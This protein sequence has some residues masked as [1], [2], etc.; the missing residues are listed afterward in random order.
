MATESTKK[1][2]KNLNGTLTGEAAVT[3]SAGS[4]DADRIPALN[5]QG[6][7]DA[8]IVNSTTSS[9]GVSDKNKLVALD[10]TG[11]ISESMFPAGF[12]SNAYSAVCSETVVAGDI[13][14]VWNDEDQIKCRKA[15]ASGGVG[16]MAVGYV[17]EGAE[18]GASVLVY[19]EGTITGLSGLTVGRVF[20]SG[21]MAGKL[22]N[23]AP[24]TDGYV[25]QDLG[26]AISDT[27]VVF[28]LGTIFVV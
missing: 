19:N 8:T 23:T 12:G 14:N 5:S 16:K 18:T 22:T 20:L 27:E 1:F 21:D 2:I 7:L 3:T 4:S 24:S 26:Y 17:K 25:V 9:S 13:V 10:S 28:G 11:K 15:D 6:V